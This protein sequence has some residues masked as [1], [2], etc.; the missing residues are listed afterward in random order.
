[1]YQFNIEKEIETYK[2]ERIKTFFNP[3]YQFN[4]EKEIET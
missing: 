3:L 4:V 1:V 2:S